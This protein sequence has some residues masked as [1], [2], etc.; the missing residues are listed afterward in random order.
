[1]RKGDADPYVS[2]SGVLLNLPGFDDQSQLDEAELNFSTLRMFELG[3]KKISGDFDLALLSKIHGHLFQDVYDWAGKLRTV[4]ISKG[5][6]RFAHHERI[7]PEAAKLFGKLKASEN[8]K[9]CHV[10]ILLINSPTFATK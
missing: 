7:Q 2:A 1:M 6:D 4:D 9:N 10:K 8:L 5:S 3:A